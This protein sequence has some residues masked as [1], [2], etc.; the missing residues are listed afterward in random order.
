MGNTDF[1][2]FVLD[3]LSALP[4]VTSRS[5]FGGLGL[6]ES[7][8]FFAIIAAGRLYFKVDEESRGLYEENGMKAFAPTPDQTLKSYYEVPV[9]VLED[10]TVLCEWA[11]RAVAVQRSA[12]AT[13]AADRKK[14]KRRES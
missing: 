11:R 3:Q 10:D 14:T 6:Y 7:G 8:V 13:R 4:D 12:Q 2:E 5:M 1:L 9:D